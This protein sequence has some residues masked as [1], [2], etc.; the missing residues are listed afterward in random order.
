MNRIISSQPLRASL[1]SF[2][3]IPSLHPQFVPAVTVPCASYSRHSHP[4]WAVAKPVKGERDLF[5]VLFKGFTNKPLEN[6]FGLEDVEQ[7]PS[8]V[9]HP[10]SSVKETEDST[11]ITVEM[12]G[13]SKEDVKIKIVDNELV[14]SGEKKIEKKDD[15]S[16]S[17]I[18]RS[19]ARKFSIDERIQPSSLSA[20]ME[21]G[22]LTIN[23]PHPKEEP[24]K[25]ADI[26]I[27]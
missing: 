19:Y 24:E 1:R 23:I 22:I 2:S 8:E 25:I 18:E 12:P 3:R 20:K 15:Q 17:V 10:R 27:S 13:L 5:D 21:H 16:S 26:Q 11:I 14:V 9:W 6:W 7:N 4:V